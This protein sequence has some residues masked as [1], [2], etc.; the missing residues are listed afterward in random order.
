MSEPER[1]LWGN[2]IKVKTIA[3]FNK[4]FDRLDSKKY[5]A[6]EKLID[7]FVDKCKKEDKKR[8]E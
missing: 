4:Y 6:M 2:R 8:G 5:V 3:L 7:G 1:K